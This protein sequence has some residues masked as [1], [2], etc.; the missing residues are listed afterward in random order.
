M[1]RIL[2]VDDES[3]IL[4][5]LSA[6]FRKAGYEVTTAKSGEQALE[7]CQT[8]EF[9]AVLSDVS[10]PGID[11]HQTVSKIRQ[12]MPD[13]VTVLMSG[14]HMECS[15]AC[16]LSTRHCTWVQKPFSPRVAVAMV[17]ESLAARNGALANEPGRNLLTP[18]A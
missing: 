9:D 17:A 15:G 4:N 1:A 12:L 16:G 14:F 3:A 6:A 7:I 18:I 10:M 11:G 2:I 5:L 13:V 8:A